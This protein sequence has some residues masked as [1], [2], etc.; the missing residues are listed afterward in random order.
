MHF[1]STDENRRLHNCALCIRLLR[2]Y[3]GYGDVSPTDALPDAERRSESVIQ[4]SLVRV[5]ISTAFEC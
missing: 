2:D 1:E 5:I 4:V 3:E